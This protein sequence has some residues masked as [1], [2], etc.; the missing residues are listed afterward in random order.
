MMK[1]VPPDKSYGARARDA[2]QRGETGNK[3]PGFDPAATP[4]ETHAEAGGSSQPACERRSQPTTDS[5]IFS[6]RHDDSNASS[7]ETGRH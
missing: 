3:I 2:I 4:L 1:T 5:E 6:V 7:H